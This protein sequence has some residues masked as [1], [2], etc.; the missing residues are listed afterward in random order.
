MSISV[1][2]SL[3]RCFLDSLELFDDVKVREG[4]IPVFEL[5]ESR[6]GTSAFLE[7]LGDDNEVDPLMYPSFGNPL[8]PYISPVAQIEVFNLLATFQPLKSEDLVANVFPFIIAQ[9]PLIGGF[10]YHHAKRVIQSVQSQIQN[11]TRFAVFCPGLCATPNG[12]AI[13]DLTIMYANAA[14]VLRIHKTSW[15]Q[16][17]F[18]LLC[19]MM[20]IQ[21]NISGYISNI[22]NVNIL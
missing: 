13:C 22:D 3:P 10:Q 1:T 14:V 12:S 8:N 15:P 17:A 16:S 7:Y 2:T 9:F 4:D 21:R 6:G 20:I 5:V 18:L 11:P 19:Q